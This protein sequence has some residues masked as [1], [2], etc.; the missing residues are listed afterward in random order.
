MRFLVVFVILFSQTVFSQQKAKK[1]YFYDENWKPIT[2]VNFE[3]KIRNNRRKLTYKAIEND[4]ATVGKIFLRENFGFLDKRK[5]VRL[6]NYLEKITNTKIDST[7]IIIVNFYFKEKRYNCKNCCIKHYT[8]DEKY[9]KSLK[10]NKGIKQFFITE[11]DFL[12]KKNNVFNDVHALI[13]KMFFK[14]VFY[15]GNYVIIKPDGEFLRY[16]GEYVQDEIIKKV[17]SDWSCSSSKK[18]ENNSVRYFNL[19]GSE[20]SESKF[21]RLRSLVKVLGIPGDSINHKKLIKREK[22]GKINDREAFEFVLEKELNIEL[23]S[24]KPIVIIYHPGKDP[25]NSSGTNDKKMIRNWY[26]E[27]EKG[28]N[29][30]AQVK[31]IY[32]C[33]EYDEIKR[34][35]R[36]L[37][38]KKDPEDM[39][40]RL[41]FKHH[42]PCSSFVVISKEGNY[43]SYFG[44]FGKKYVWKATNIMNK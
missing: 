30:I 42:Y 24:D 1:E 15:C 44:E 19:D 10:K 2:R 29:K 4:T 28:L 34:A 39:I 38:W 16:Y 14:Y 18:I 8:S 22:R 26:K 21:N 13:Q 33:K 40:E 9:I 37:D 31:P 20:I 3:K 5:K 7:D 23:D 6:V 36:I 43:I 41:F 35:A 12:F 32:I 27:L 17:N 11:K 25:C